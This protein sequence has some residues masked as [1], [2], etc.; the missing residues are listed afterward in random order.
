MAE[1]MAKEKKRSASADFFVRLVREKPLGTFGGAITLLFLLTAIFSGFLAPYEMND[2]GVAPRLS[3][4]SSGYP[5]GS[6][7]LGRDM[8][9]RIIY[10]A[11]ISV[12]VGLAA[13]TLATLISTILGGLSGFFGGKFD[14]VVQRF[15]DGWMSF[16]GLIVLIVA[17]TLVGPGLWQIITVMGVMTGIGGSRIVRSAVI[18]IKENVYVEASRAVGCS[19]TRILVWHILPNIMGVV[20]ILYTT[21]VPLM[22]LQEASLSFLG[23]GIPP[24][25]PTWGGM[26]SID[27]RRYMLQ[28]P[29]LAFW[30]GLALSTVVYG[31]SMFGDAV[32]DLLDP[33]LRGGGGRYSGVEAKLKKRRQKGKK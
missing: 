6:D 10:G 20:F 24:P 22:I 33:R 7:Q 28:S 13:T 17:V 11:R 15:V 32:R 23:L 12:I 25:A 30:P 21:R 8:L 19:T 18:G 26:L 1:A 4:P 16:P 31:V 2:I 27:G 5:L 9:S 29:W 3:A 14:L